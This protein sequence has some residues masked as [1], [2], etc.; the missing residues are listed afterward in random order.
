M[1]ICLD[2]FPQLKALN[3]RQ[4]AFVMAYHECHNATEAARLAG[5]SEKTAGQLGSRLAGKKHIRAAIEELREYFF[6]Q[7][8]MSK[9]EAAALLSELARG[10]VVDLLD[11]AGEI[12]PRL[13]KQ[14]GGASLRRVKTEETKWG[15]NREIEMA[16]PRAA[17]DTLGKIMGWFEKEKSVDLGGFVF[18]FDL[19]GKK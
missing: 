14:R 16:D 19:T 17:I 5:Y 15:V 2:D 10:R 11:E 7:Q 13:F 3:D 9:T 1:D 18:N 12:S 8:I 4:R 6:Q